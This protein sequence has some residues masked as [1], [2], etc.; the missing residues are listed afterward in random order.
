[1]PVTVD[2]AP[3]EAEALGL[4]TVGH[5]LSHLQKGNRLVV[6]LL[7]DGQEPDPSRMGEIRRR[8]LTDHSIFIETTDPREMS[9]SIL[10]EVQAQLLQAD[11]IKLEAVEL[12]AR[13]LTVKAMEK[14]SGCFAS[15]QNARET[16]AGVA[17]LLKLDLDAIVIETKPLTD[18]MLEFTAQLKE[19]KTSLENRDFV[20]LSDLLIYETTQTSRQWRQALDEV[21]RMIG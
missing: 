12:I 10:K 9:R 7:V 1:M 21:D 20:T 19:I 18:L 8:S 16:V 2:H 14:L 6:N 3:L 17:Q 15:W 11:Q 5:V 13:N 4:Q